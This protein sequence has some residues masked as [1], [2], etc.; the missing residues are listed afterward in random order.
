MD[1]PQLEK[2]LLDSLSDSRL[3][4]QERRELRDFVQALSGP[5]RNFVRNRAFDLAKDAMS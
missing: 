5:E 3:D 1:K 4:N 2:L